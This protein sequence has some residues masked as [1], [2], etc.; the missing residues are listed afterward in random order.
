MSPHPPSLPPLSPTLLTNC[1]H[2]RVSSGRPVALFFVAFYFMTGIC[3]LG[4][5]HAV[6]LKCIT[7]LPSLLP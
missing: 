2:V 7:L 4:I 5:V 6:L 1:R 3:L